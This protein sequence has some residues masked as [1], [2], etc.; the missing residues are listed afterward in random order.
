MVEERLNELHKSAF[1]QLV[2]KLKRKFAAPIQN[3]QIKCFN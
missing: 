3:L 2:P 1:M